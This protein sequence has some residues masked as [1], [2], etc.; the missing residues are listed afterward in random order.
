[1]LKNKNANLSR[2][3]NDFRHSLAFA[4]ALPQLSLLGFVI[5]IVAGTIIVAF[6]MAM[7]LSLDAVLPGGNDSFESLPPDVRTLFIFLG[8]FFLGITYHFAGKA[9]SEIGVSHVIHRLQNHQ[10]KLPFKN[11]CVQFAGAFICMVSGQSVG[12]EGPAVHLGAGA[13]SQFGQWLRLPNNSMHTL[14][15]CGIAAA[16]AA[17]FDTPM[18]GVIF[19]MEVVVMEYTI[20]GFLPVLL[21]SV[22]G[23]T[24][25]QLTFGKESLF[26]VGETNFATLAEMPYM[27]LCGLII[28]LFA[29]AYTYL[30]IFA[31]KQRNKPLWVRLLVAG[32]LTAA[33][34]YFVPEIM[35]MGY[36]TVNMALTGQLGISA[37]LIIVLAKLLVTPTVIGLGIPGGLIGP[38]IVIGA[39][40]GNA[41]GLAGASVFPE[42]QANA[43]FYVILGMTGMIAATL[44]APLTALVTVLELTY[45]PNL[46]FPAM[47]VIVTSCISTRQLFR[48][49]SIFIEQLKLSGRTVESNPME[50]ALKRV[51][52]RSIMDRLFVCTDS[53]IT[54]AKALTLL[55]LNPNWIVTEEQ[56]ENDTQLYALKASDLANYVAD[57]GMQQDLTNPVNL[58]EI[59]GERKRL[60]PIGENDNLLQALTRFNSVNTESL[61]VRRK[62]PSNSAMNEIQGIITKTAVDNYYQPRELKNVMG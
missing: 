24:I 30:N 1:M 50:N 53:N 28:S 41:L 11:W 49:D 7:Y 2:P 40:L 47:L 3:L 26:T 10:G 59:P 31:L 38:L 17:A 48:L 18:A 5:G 37:L 61:Y 43:S 62:H 34:A 35:G 45:N 54:L 29:A 27:V 56:E 22:M 33:V 12:R 19:A 42:Y 23:T 6:R 58:L 44:N 9:G 14:I 36:D 46:I 15:A 13:A 57:I 21:A 52:V 39:C 60:Y 4:D 25:S 51:G 32:G 8:I 20:A 55:D 16:I